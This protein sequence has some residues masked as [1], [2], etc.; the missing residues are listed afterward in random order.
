[1][2]ELPESLANIDECYVQNADVNVQETVDRWE[3]ASV[4]IEN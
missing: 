1:L 4:D 2:L 3:A